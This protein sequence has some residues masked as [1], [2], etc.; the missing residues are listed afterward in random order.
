MPVT[1]DHPSGS[2]FP[3]GVTTVLCTGFDPVSKATGTG[4]FTVTVLI[5]PPVIHLPPP[6]T[7]A[8]GLTV[9]ADSAMGAMVT[10]NVTATDPFG[11]PVPVLCAPSSP[12]QFPLSMGGPGTNVLCEAT[13]GGHTTPAHFAVFVVD[14]TPPVLH[15]PGPITANGGPGGAVVN[16][17]ATATDL[18]SGTFP[19]TCAPTS[20]ST[21][22]L[23]TTTV[24]CN[25][26]DGA[27]NQAI[28]GTFT[29][30]V[31][32]PNTPPVVTVPANMTVE[33]TSPTGATVTFTATASDAQDGPITPTCMPASGTPFA[34]GTKPVICKATDSGGLSASRSFT[35]T[36]AD[37]KG[38]VWSNVPGTITAFATS[39]AGATVSYTKPTATDAVDLA[40]AV[41]CTPASGSPF[42]AKKTTVTCTASDTRN[43]QAIPATF[44]VWVTYQAPTDG[45]FFLFPIRS[46]G[47]S[48]FRIGRPVPARFRLTGASAGITNLVAKL[49][50]TKISNTVQGTIVDVSDETVDDTDFIFKYRPL[51]R[52]YAYRWRTI[53]QTQGTFQL[54]AD[55][56]DG[57]VHQVNVSLRP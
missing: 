27:G 53:G 45:T 38:P 1:C 39:T 40:R 25:A 34:I 44:I 49:V 50:V 28:T 35:V 4:R 2:T 19:A 46:N 3:I 6:I 13:D 37:T 12:A 7:E 21:F 29:V 48:I 8:E 16:Y 36:V 5:G 55:L 23:G 32:N 57:V 54:K 18:V 41:N 22:L 20:G 14:T 33:A 9:E 42:A 30:T 31:I 56:G 15:L 26:Q 43:N 51:L 11:G 17:T 52:W 10:Y 24:H 47:S